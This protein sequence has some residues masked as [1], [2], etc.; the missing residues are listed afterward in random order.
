MSEGPTD[1]TRASRE[2]YFHA[3]KKN[4]FYSKSVCHSTQDACAKRKSLA[5]CSRV[6]RQNQIKSDFIACR[7]RIAWKSCEY[8][9]GNKVFPNTVT[10]PTI[11]KNAVLF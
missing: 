1:K 7:V 10:V 4:Q 5:Q 8:D 2:R 11:R 9:M 3:I 6:P